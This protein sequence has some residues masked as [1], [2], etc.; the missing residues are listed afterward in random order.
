MRS[1]GAATRGGWPQRRR[2]AG[3]SRLRAWALPPQIPDGLLHLR[4]PS[5]LHARTALQ[6]RRR[7][8]E[9]AG[10]ALEAAWERLQLLAAGVGPAAAGDEAAE[11]ALARHLVRGEGEAAAD[12]LLRYQQACTLILPYPAY[13]TDRVRDMCVY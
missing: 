6:A 2:S 11:T 9:A 8:R 13:V 5:G 10:K 3:D 4:P 12:A 1:G 7:R